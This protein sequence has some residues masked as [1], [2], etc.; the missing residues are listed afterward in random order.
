MPILKR[1]F[2]FTVV[3][4]LGFVVDTAV[5]YAL[6]PEAG[7]YLGRVVSFL[8]AAMVTWIL[9]RLWT[10]GDRVSPYSVRSE[11]LVYVAVMITGGLVNYSVYAWL[12]ASS[13]HVRL[14]PILGVAAGSL[15]GVSVNFL[16][17]RLL[18]FNGQRHAE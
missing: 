11:M 2:L 14:E 12:V 7:L 13:S 16:A 9:N 4:A 17:A 5:L 10:F 3:G 8:C 1:I 18:V 6:K 15:S